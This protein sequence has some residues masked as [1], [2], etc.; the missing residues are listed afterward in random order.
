MRMG[1]G[2]SY[3]PRRSRITARF[4]R[5][6]TRWNETRASTR[7]PPGRC[8]RTSPTP[9]VTPATPGGLMTGD[10]SLAQVGHAFIEKARDLDVK[11]ICA[12]K[13]FGGGS[14]YATPDRCAFRGSGLPRRRASSSTTRDTSERGPRRAR[15]PRRT[16]APGRQPLDLRDET[17]RGRPERKRLH[18][19]RLD[20]VDDH[21]RPNAVGARAREAAEVRRRGQRP[22]GHRLHLLR[23]S[24]RPDPDLPFIRD[25]KGVPGALRVS[26]ADARAEGQ[27]AGTER[28]PRLRGR[29]GDHPRLQVHPATSC[30]DIRRQVGGKHAT[31]GPRNVAEVAMVREHH[32][33][34]PG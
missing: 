6:L 28:R 15:T 9:S 3:T 1:V 26:G 5:T 25:L 4:R 7:L 34:W 21:A 2:C 16:G 29:A 10:P 12:H 11:I 23:L 13:G 18:R 19:A 30:E 17:S 24:S 33:G 14:E 31:H 32:Q 22:L 8:S 20:L 27:G